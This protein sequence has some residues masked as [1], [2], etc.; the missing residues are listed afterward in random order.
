MISG[1]ILASGFSR[2]MEEE[3]LLLPVGGVSLVEHVIRA[4]QA[5]HL[6]E[7]ILIYRNKSIKEIGQRYIMRMVCNDH[8]DEG[9]SAA[10]KLGISAAHQ[11]TDAFMFMVGDQPF[12]NPLVINTLIAIFKENPRHIIV[13]VYNGKRGNPVIFPSQFKNDLLTLSGDGGG[14]II[15][16]KSRNSV[17]LVEIGDSSVGCDIDTQ[18]EYEKIEKNRLG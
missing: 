17:K 1:I 6:N 2:R 10:I 16:E 13:P 11:E 12:L 18:E 15:I 9:Q 5:S 4:A 14:R 8:A 3:K 7:V